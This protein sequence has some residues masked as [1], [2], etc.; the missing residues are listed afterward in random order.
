MI[1]ISKAEI[2]S[3]NTR[4]CVRDVFKYYLNHLS[5]RINLYK[6]CTITDTMNR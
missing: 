5:D 3:L 1:E 6:S 4:H 2:I